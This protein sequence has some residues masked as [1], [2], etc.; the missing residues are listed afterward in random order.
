[1]HLSFKTSARRG[2]RFDSSRLAVKPFAYLRDPLFLAGCALYALNRW[3]VKPHVHGAFLHS[4]FNDLLLIPCALPP[5]LLVHRALRLRTHDAPPTWPEIGLHLLFWSWLFEWAGPHLF[6]RATG[7]LFDVAAYVSGGLVA[8]A[9]WN[10]KL[11]FSKDGF[12][13]I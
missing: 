1:M 9:W 4:W 5:L 7:D 12:H 10:R 8:W 3:L 11:V 6:Q 13:G 2:R